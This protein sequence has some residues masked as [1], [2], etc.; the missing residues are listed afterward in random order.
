[1]HRRHRKQCVITAVLA[2][3]LSTGTA[4]PA[5]AVLRFYYDPDDG[6]VSFDTTQTDTGVVFSYSLGINRS[7]SSIRFNTENLVRLTNSMFATV[8]DVLIG[9][10]TTSNPLKGLFTIGNVLPSGLSEETWN[11]TFG[12]LALHGFHPITNGIVNYHITRK[13]SHF[14]LD[15]IG[16]GHPEPAELFY[17]PPEGEFDNRWDIVDPDTLDWAQTAILTYRAWS[18]EVII[19][20]T[21]EDSGYITSFLLKSNN[22][23]L[24]ANFTPFI[25]SPFN[26]SRPDLIGQVADAVEPG[27]YSLG[28]ILQ[29]GMTLQEFEATFTSARFLERAGFKGGSFDFEADGL[30][31]QLVYQ[32]IPEPSTMMILAAPLA[33]ILLRRKQRDP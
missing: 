24:P 22:A 23:F 6:N 7:L 21:G 11:E 16:Q 18:G 14:Y 12:T 8:T 29:P 1:M 4:S 10:G 30:A 33:Q 9:E 32:A 3:V 31:M 27:Q 5:L 28:N 13:G 17:G 20:T 2:A 19:D 26:T 25:D 15:A